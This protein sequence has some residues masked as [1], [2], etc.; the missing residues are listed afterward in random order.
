MIFEKQLPRNQR[1][2]FARF[3]AA[4]WKDLGFPLM[5]H[6]G[7]SREPLEDWFSDRLG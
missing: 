5:D 2:F 6:R 1:R 7:R 3:L 4:A